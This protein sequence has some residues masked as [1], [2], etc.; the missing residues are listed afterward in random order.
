MQL[1]KEKRL[2][3]KI[4]RKEKEKRKREKRKKNRNKRKGIRI[5][6]RAEDVGYRH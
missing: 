4:K 5:N 2:F 6:D 3:F 1:K